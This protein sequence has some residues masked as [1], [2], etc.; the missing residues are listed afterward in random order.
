MTDLKRKIIIDWFVDG[1]YYDIV[2]AVAK[3][4]TSILSEKIFVDN[5]NYALSIYFT[6][7]L[8]TKISVGN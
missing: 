7:G 8:L 3:T 6:K 2:K 5:K 4:L 1:F